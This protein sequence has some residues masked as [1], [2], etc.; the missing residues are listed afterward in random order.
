M[1]ELIMVAWRDIPAHILVKDGRK[2][3]RRPLSARF[4]KAIDRAAMR[5][6]LTDSDAYLGE[7]RRVVLSIHPGE[8]E[9]LADQTQ[10]DIEVR[11]DAERLA[12]LVQNGGFEPPSD[13]S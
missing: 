8:P 9:A 6:G 4:E 11:Y 5:A 10:A 13:P 1:L 12:A 7:W 2:T 3:I